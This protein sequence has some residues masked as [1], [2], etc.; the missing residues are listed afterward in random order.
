ME[1]HER[2]VVELMAGALSGLVG[3]GSKRKLDG[4]IVWISP[5][6]AASEALRYAMAAKALADGARARI[7]EKRQAP[8]AKEMEAED[9]EKVIKM[10]EPEDA[11]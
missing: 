4:A 8:P 9:P 7:R 11:S 5:A 1:R 6:A 2:E 10:P 3:R